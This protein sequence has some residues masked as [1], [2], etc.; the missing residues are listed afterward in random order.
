MMEEWFRL[1][2]NK[3]VEHMRVSLAEGMEPFWFYMTILAP[4]VYKST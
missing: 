3:E 2:T 1:S 4:K